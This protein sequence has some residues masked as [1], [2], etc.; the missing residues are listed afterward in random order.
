MVISPRA[1]TTGPSTGL[2]DSSRGVRA[3]S[4]EPQSWF[5][6]RLPPLWHRSFLLKSLTLTSM[7]DRIG[8]NISFQR[9][10]VRGGRGLGPLNSKR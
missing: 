2:E 1:V 7:P 9:T 3:C 5:Q 10:R 8:P 4:I 6:E